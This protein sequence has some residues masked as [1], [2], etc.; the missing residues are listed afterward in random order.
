MIV[1]KA[2][3]AGTAIKQVAVDVK[4]KAAVVAS[5]AYEGVVHGAEKAA[6]LAVDAKDKVVEVST[7]LYAVAS[8]KVAEGYA[9]TK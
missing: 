7:N 3:E 2:G 1:E 5:N 6:E 9:A 8:E 4:D